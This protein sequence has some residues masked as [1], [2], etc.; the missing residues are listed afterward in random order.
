VKATGLVLALSL[1]SA[2]LLSAQ[3]VIPDSVFHR[4]SSP[5][6]VKYGKWALLAAAAGMG[7]KAAQAHNDAEHA[8]DDLRGYCDPDPIRCDQAAN[9]DY[10]DSRAESIY[11]RS[12]SADRRSRRWLAGGEISFLGAMG[13]FVWELSRPK[14]PSKN[15]PFEP[16]VGVRGSVT[17]VGVRLTF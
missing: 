5:A 11:Q 17:D 3:Q 8:F 15:I 16:T 12:L 14:G 10:L 1:L 2:H 6:L 13:L 7:V 9:G 4:K